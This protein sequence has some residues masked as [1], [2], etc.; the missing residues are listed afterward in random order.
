MSIVLGSADKKTTVRLPS[1]CEPVVDTSGG[2]GCSAASL[3]GYGP[4][5]VKRLVVNADDFGF[6][7]D[8]NE[9]IIRSHV[10]GIVR[11]TSLMANG[12]A[13]EQAVRLARRHPQ[14]GVGCHLTL[15]QGGSVARPGSELPASLGAFLAAWPGRDGMVSEF[16]AQVEKL[17]SHGI[18]PTHVDTHKHLHLL[19]PV[20]DAL[21]LV[22][23]EY[24]IRWVR[25]PFDIPFGLGPGVR[26]A[27]GLTARM[28]RLPFEER[29]VKAHCQ[30]SDYFAGFAATGALGARRLAALLASL[31]DGLG[32]FVCHPGVCGPELSRA[33]TRLKESRE[34]EMAALCSPLVKQVIAD[35]GI[36]VVSYREL[37]RNE[38]GSNS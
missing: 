24:A 17:V 29:L 6:T 28:F 35:R 31:P 7:S 21:V 32:E 18:R 27:L 22:A 9:G 15:V 14:L 3:L 11:S 19:P 10:D 2:T 12:S 13:F 34:A 20:L 30:T 23:D 33:E 37:S 5:R 36:E 8:V 25:K 38:A 4:Y 26:A 16:R 1:P